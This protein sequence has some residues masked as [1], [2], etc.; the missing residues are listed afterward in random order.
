MSFP[1]N[2]GGASR[3]PS[4]LFGDYELVINEVLDGDPE[5][6]RRVAEADAADRRGLA[7][8]KYHLGRHKIPL[9]VHVQAILRSCEA[10][11]E[12]YEA[13]VKTDMKNITVH[14]GLY[15]VRVN[16]GDEVFD[17]SFKTHQ[18]AREWRDRVKLL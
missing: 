14:Q 9:P 12:F 1:M 15:R 17:R 3:L 10:D 4:E 11:Q 6:K 7:V 5:L 2:T 8:L 13:T 16:L 18:E